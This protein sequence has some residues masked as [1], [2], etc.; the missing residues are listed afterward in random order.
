M[1]YILITFAGN[2]GPLGNRVKLIVRWVGMMITQL[3]CE[4]EDCED[5]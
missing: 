4:V 5:H 2:E 1:S 3:N